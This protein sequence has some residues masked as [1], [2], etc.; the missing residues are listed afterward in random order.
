MKMVYD[1]IW[2]ENGMYW[3]MTTL[4]KYINK[5][6]IVTELVG[7]VILKTPNNHKLHCVALCC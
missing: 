7:Y 3:V 2:Y 4:N 6:E 1:M 5:Q